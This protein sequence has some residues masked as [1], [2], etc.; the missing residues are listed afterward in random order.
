MRSP[1]FR[2]LLSKT[3]IDKLT[4]IN[5]TN[6]AIDPNIFQLMLEYIYTDRCPWLN[7]MQKIKERNDHEYAM[8]LAQMKNIDDD[9][10]DHRYFARIRQ[11]SA[12]MPS[13]H[14]QKH[15]TKSKKKKKSASMR[16][17]VFYILNKSF[18]LRQ[19]IPIQ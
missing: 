14:H 6:T 16:R 8:Y 5:E 13:H 4:I 1:Y 11:Q 7:L 17:L 3:Q 12:M 15:G 10:D 2:Q 18:T 19:S 9:I